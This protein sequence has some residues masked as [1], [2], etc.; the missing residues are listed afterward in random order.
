MSN[1]KELYQH[2]VNETKKFFEST[3][4]NK[5][6]IGL[7]G[8]IDS[9]LVATITCDALGPGN[10]LGICMPSKY[11]SSESVTDSQILAGNLGIISC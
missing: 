5:A 4:F 6:V 7:S 9:A 1:V 10:V 8:G 3:G 11:S 2:L